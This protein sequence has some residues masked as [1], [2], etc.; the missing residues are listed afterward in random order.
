MAAEKYCSISAGT[1]LTQKASGE[2]CSHN[3]EC[4]LELCV[5]SKCVT[6][7]QKDKILAIVG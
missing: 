6:Q 1:W 4:S 5:K 3:F 7:E 2:L